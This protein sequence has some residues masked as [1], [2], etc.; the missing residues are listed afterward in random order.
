MSED[1]F[2][3]FVQNAAALVVLFP[4]NLLYLNAMRQIQ[5]S[6]SAAA[7]VETRKAL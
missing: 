5:P 1:T 4:M 7:G 6:S 2:C 3:S